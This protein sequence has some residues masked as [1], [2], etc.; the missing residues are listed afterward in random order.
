LPFLGI[1]EVIAATMD[2]VPV[3]DMP[4]LAAILAVDARARAVASKQLQQ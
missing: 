4:D 2:A 3:A 1:A